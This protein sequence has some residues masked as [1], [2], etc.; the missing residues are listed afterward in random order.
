V[1]DLAMQPLKG[2]PAFPTTQR[3]LL[4][5]YGITSAEAFFDHAIHDAQGL[6]RA[7]HVSQ[8]E[9]DRLVTLAEGHLTRGFVRRCRQPVT[10]HPRGVIVD[11]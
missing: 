7:L 8:A 6:R 1:R 3:S 2:I 5:Q 9:L 4:E 11:G 10:K